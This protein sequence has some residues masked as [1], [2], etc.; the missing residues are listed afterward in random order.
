MHHPTTP[1]TKHSERKR[2]EADKTAS[3]E[4]KQEPTESARYPRHLIVM[5]MDST[6]IDEEVIDLIAEEAGVGAQI[7]AI[8]EAAMRGEIDFREALARR[9]RMLKGTPLTVFPKVLA[10]IHF[11]Q[12]ALRL[13]A[14]AHKRGWK[15]GVVSGGFHEIVDDLVAQAGIDYSLAN[16]LGTKNDA[17]DGSLNGPIIDKAAKLAAL[18]EWCAAEGL[19]LSD[20]ITIGDG[21][22]DIPMLQAAGFGIAFCAKPIVREAAS[23]QIAE[24]DLMKTLPLIDAFDTANLRDSNTVTTTSTASEKR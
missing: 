11:T 20:A 23:A 4:Q 21:A 3:P 19:A 12:G 15:V 6:L 17:L 10:H 9:V 13:I 16:R 18:E 8:T 24:R 1:P 14:S 7:A 5:D 2:T 22:N